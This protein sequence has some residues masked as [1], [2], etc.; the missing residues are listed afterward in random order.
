MDTQSSDSRGGINYQSPER[1]H[2]HV[3][4]AQWAVGQLGHGGLVLVAGDIGGGLR[5]A[6]GDN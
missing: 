1:G 6:H 4:V 3:R 5:G 2:D